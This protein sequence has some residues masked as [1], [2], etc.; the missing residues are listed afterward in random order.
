MDRE[1]SSVIRK[2]MP[3]IAYISFS[4]NEFAR[5]RTLATYVDLSAS[6]FTM[7]ALSFIRNLVYML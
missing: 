2:I 7:F 5:N 1:E 4:E 6:E 3:M